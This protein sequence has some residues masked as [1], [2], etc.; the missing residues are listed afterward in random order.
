MWTDFSLL[1]ENASTF[2]TKVDLL[3]F[4][5]VGLSVFFSALIFLLIL[6]FSIRY[7]RRSE[8]ERPRAIPGDLR[9]ELTWSL[10]PLGMAMVVF[11]WATSLYF[12]LFHPPANAMEIYVVAKQWMWKLQHPEGKR[13]INTLHVPVGQPVRLTMTSEDVIHS[14][15]VPA[16]RTKMDVLPG[17]YTT[18]WFEATKIGEYHLFCTEYCGTKHSKMIGRVVVMEPADYQMWLSGSSGEP[19]EVA[20]E[21]LFDQLGCR[22]CHRPDSEGRGPVVDGLFG[23]SVQLQSGET[24]MADEAYLRESILNPNAKLLAGYKPLMPTFEG[25]ISEEGILQLIEYIKSLKTPER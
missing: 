19:M 16:F 4:T 10:I 18:T 9:L 22:T 14:F 17:R 7:R 6:F 5:L 20:G 11:V 25:Q 2:A 15:F 3:Y 23:K 24:A 12:S 1:P 21:R 8:D 13:E